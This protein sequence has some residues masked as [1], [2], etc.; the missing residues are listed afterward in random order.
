MQ[1]IGQ[2]ID[3]ARKGEETP[4]RHKNPYVS[5]S[6]T[7]KEEL[8]TQSEILSK[9]SSES[10]EG[11]FKNSKNDIV[12]EIGSY[13]GHMLIELS[14]NNPSL[15]FLGLDITYKRVVKTALKIQSAQLDNCKVSMIEAQTLLS[16][17]LKKE[18]LKGLCIFFPD[19]WP[20]D[21]QKKHRLLSQK[22]FE[23]AFQLLKKDGF[24]WLKTDSLAY[25]SE[26]ICIAAHNNFKEDKASRDNSTPQELKGGP[27]TSI[28]EKLFLSQGK[29]YYSAILRKI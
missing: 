1:N 18:I 2:L 9:A 13:Y 7:L 26:A 28:F 10:F 4:D 22:F 14:Q 6:L 20:K 24:I 27:Y 17:F 16:F 25:Y 8:Y 29:K 23:N 19:P 21:R 3:K 15:N 5:K 12:L 11:V